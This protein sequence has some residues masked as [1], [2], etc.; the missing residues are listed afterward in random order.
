MQAHAE[1][2]PC[3]ACRGHGLAVFHKRGYVVAQCESCGTRFVPEG[4]VEL[5]RYDEAYF[6]GACSD[7]GYGG[8]VADRAL[9]RANF[10]RRLRWLL[11]L[12]TGRCL[13]D[14][15]AA[16]GL[17]VEA[18]A[19]AGFDAIGLEPAPAC[20]DFA[21]RELDVEVRTGRIED[22]E[23]PAEAFDVVTMFDVIEHL[24]DPAAAVRRVRTLLRPG[25]LLIVETGDRDAALARLMGS[26]WYFYD[27]PQHVTFF[28]RASLEGMLVRSGFTEAV[29]VGYLGRAVSLR[30]FAHQL[31]RA[32]GAGL[33][34]DLSRGL[35]RSRFGELRFRVPDRG[36]AFALAVRRGD[37]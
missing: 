17:F 3:R 37:V 6:A 32:L 29:A 20:A 24:A 14:V 19:H 22:A 16:Y 31:G 35:A 9:V 13:L 18:A 7:G 25:G 11:P 23:L 10:E 30:N 28:S 2:Y 26:G 33:L 12:A 34:G 5:P 27:P 1:I 4:H 21:R 8:Y 15:G 36:N